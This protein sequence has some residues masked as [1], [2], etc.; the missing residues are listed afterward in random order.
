MRSIVRV[1]LLIAITITLPL[2]CSAQADDTAVI[3]KFI[4]AQA[5]KEKG[6]EP[7]GVRKTITGDVNHDGVADTVVLYTIEG[8]NGS[9]NYI[10][11]LAVFLR[12]NG[13]LTYATHQA[14]GGKNHRSVDLGQ[15]TDGVI[16]LEFTDYSRNDPSCCPTLKHPGK[17]VFSAGVLKEI[18]P[19]GGKTT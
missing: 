5:K 8:Q 4:A 18:R 13:K 9:N 10:Q 3:D 6:E 14:V 1:L 7:E 15:I 17:Y 19:K 16:N 2:L 12:V 11:Y